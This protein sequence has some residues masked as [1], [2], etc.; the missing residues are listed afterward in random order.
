MPIK[1]RVRAAGLSMSCQGAAQPWKG[2][3]LARGTKGRGATRPSVHP[4]VL[5]SEASCVL[6][7]RL[8]T[9]THSLGHAPEARLGGTDHSHL[10]NEIAEAQRRG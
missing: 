4:S 7:P 9:F 3:A 5:P 8:G 1:V 6:G 10:T 2:P